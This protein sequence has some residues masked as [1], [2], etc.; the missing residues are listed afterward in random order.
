MGY[1]LHASA[2]PPLAA[3]TAANRAV[4][5]FAAVT[6]ANHAAARSIAAATRATRA[7]SSIGAITA[8]NRTASPISAITAANRTAASALGA[9]VSPS[10]A[11]TISKHILKTVPTPFADLS[12]LWP[13]STPSPIAAAANASRWNA[14]SIV[15]KMW[16]PNSAIGS[17]YRKL[18]AKLDDWSKYLDV[19][20]SARHLGE[21]FAAWF[22][23]YATVRGPQTFAVAPHVLRTL[24]AQATIRA[25]LLARLRLIGA[26]PPPGRQATSRP[27]LVRGPTFRG[28]LHTSADSPIA[29]AAAA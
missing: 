23:R 29:T 25:L 16:N 19:I 15:G 14:D 3:V 13:R 21:A 28:V 20:T 4:S 27:Q 2:H 10:A 9:M 1:A 5:S 22:Y 8:A 7:A 24:E 6:A 17:T 12:K 26:Q 11:S 18:A